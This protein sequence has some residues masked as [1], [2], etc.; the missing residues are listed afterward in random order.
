MGHGK[1]KAPESP[2]HVSFDYPLKCDLPK[3]IQA[4]EFAQYGTINRPAAPPPRASGLPKESLRAP[5]SASN[6]P[7][8]ARSRE[9][10]AAEVERYIAQRREARMRE[11]RSI[12]PTYSPTPPLDSIGHTDNSTSIWLK[13]FVL[14]LVM[15]GVFLTIA[16]WHCQLSVCK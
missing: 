11:A 9:G 13:L 8:V 15:A 3:S 6:L 5:M 16:W 12:L 4:N 2:R 7:S 1:S 14:L 10:A